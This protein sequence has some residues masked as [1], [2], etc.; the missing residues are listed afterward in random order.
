MALDV[1]HQRNAKMLVET[2]TARCGD[3]QFEGDGGSTIIF[4]NWAAQNQ[5]VLYSVD[6]S[7]ASLENANMA[8]QSYSKYIH[9]I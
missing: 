3:Q 7:S 2:G 1:L 4:G 9:F 8:T 6:I 5:S